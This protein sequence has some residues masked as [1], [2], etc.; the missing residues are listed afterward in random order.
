MRYLYGDSAPFPHSF[1]FLATLERFMA[2][3]TK[4]VKLESE[5]RSLESTSAASAA[6]RIKSLDEL[7]T[8]HEAVILGVQES[9]RRAT[10][11]QTAEYA[12][13]V[14]E[15]AVRLVED[16]RRTTTASNDREQAQ[17]RADVERRRNEI[18]QSLEN[19]LTTGRLPILDAVIKTR[20][21]GS[22]LMT[23]VLTYPDVFVYSY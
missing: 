12:L 5:A 20:W 16:A 2:A 18:R 15:N 17:V 1:N 19:F 7:E 10:H 9:A 14:V 22:Y 11:R 4:V 23:C 6:A 13:Q 21:E 8:F 3:A